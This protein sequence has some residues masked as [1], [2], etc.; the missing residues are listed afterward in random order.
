[1][2]ALN[3]IFDYLTGRKQRVKINSSFSS[4]LDT[5]QGV[6]QGSILG[7]LLF[8]LFLCDLF[9]FVEEADIMSYADDNTPH[10]CSENIDVTLEKLEEVGKV[11]FEWFS[12]NFLKANADKC[13]L[14]LSTDEPFSINIDNEVI[15]NSNNKKLLGINLNNRLGFDT[16][17]ANI[18]SRVSKK[19]HA[20][21][22]ISQ[23][24]S[25][26]KRR[27]T[28]KAFIASEFGYCPLVWMF[29]SRKLNSRVN[30]LHERAL[31]I[32]YQDYASSFTELLEKDNSTTI[33]NRNIQLLATELFK[34][35]NG[36]SP[37]FMNKIFVENAQ[38]YYD[39][40]KKAEFKRTNVKTVY[41][42]TETLTFLGPRIWEIVPDYIKK[43]NSFEEFKL[44]IKLWNPEN[45][46]CRLCKRFLPQVRFL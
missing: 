23:Y 42:G 20:L 43:S 6:P 36:L 14:I 34:V 2:N 29:H 44:K 1:M 15:K 17:V 26:H 46:P 28:M 25:I 27:M 8:N 11:L 24:M 5:F 39:L 37:P 9:L 19:L 30:K 35:K 22:R 31:R 12:N 13:H 7:P 16:H 41:N 3:L 45:C 32:V 40:R 4:Y 38:H 18:C 21:A 10:V 33:H